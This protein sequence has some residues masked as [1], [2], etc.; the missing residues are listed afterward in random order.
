MSQPQ[1][2]LV[3]RASDP[4]AELTTLH[5]LANNYP[6]LRPYIAENPRTYPALLE[7]LGTLGDP[8]VDAA[9]ARRTASATTQALSPEQ[10]REA[11]QAAAQ[12]DVPNGQIS[13]T[14]P[15]APADAAGLTQAISQADVARAVTPERRPIMEGRQIAHDATPTAAQIHQQQPPQ[16][17]A[18][19]TYPQQPA[20]QQGPPAQPQQPT[21]PQQ[22]AY[23]QGRPAYPQQP[24]QPQPAYQPAQPAYPQQSPQQPAADNQGVFGVGMPESEEQ[25]GSSNRW[26][27]I[28]GGIALV[29]VVALIV[30][31]FTSDHG[32]SDAAPTTDTVQAEVPQAS[33]AAPT[34]KETEDSPSPT[35]S[36]SATRHLTAPAPAE[37]IEMSA[38]T[39]PSGNISCV[40]TDDSVSCTINEHDFIP[41]DSSCNDSNAQAFTASVD[42]EGQATGS[43]NIAFS[44]TGASLSYG[45]S[46]KNDAFACTSSESGVDCW[47]QVSG[48][49]FQLSRSNADPTSR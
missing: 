8:A 4:N 7:W 38:F 25:R 12:P 2:D 1:D 32:G 19:P 15:D 10:A 48:N 42:T 31:F 27:W 9:L 26:L 45:A 35:P 47:S 28:L 46:A 16:Q 49:G 13:P 34:P 6:G 43:C 17:P 20:F 5:E 33:S 24:V 41:T 29:L 30:W 36:P 22:P 23:Q 21:Y 11:I 14:G 40:L 37:A 39:T 44:A 18:Q 3:A